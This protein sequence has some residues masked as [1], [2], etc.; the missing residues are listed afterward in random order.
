MALL[1]SLL[2][3]VREGVREQAKRSVAAAELAAMAQTLMQYRSM[4]GDFPWLRAGEDDAVRLYR[5][6]ADR[7][8]PDGRI[9]KNPRV[10]P[11][12]AQLQMGDPRTLEA[13][14]SPDSEGDAYVILDPWGQPYRYAYRSGSMDSVWQCSGFVL[15]SVG[16]SGAVSVERSE[17]EDPGIPRSGLI[18]D[19][20]LWSAHSISVT[21]DNI[22][23]LP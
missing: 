20:Y 6:L 2:L 12:L 10:F 11:V 17:R 3:A 5:A 18:D 14:R 13:I 22:F 15:L 1:G 4:H 16:P 21:D 7:D 9:V 23:A 19:T 8:L